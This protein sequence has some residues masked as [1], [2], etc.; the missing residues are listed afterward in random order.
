MELKDGLELPLAPVELQPALHDFALWRTCFDACESFVRLAEGDYALRL[1]VPLGVLRARYAV[2][3]HVIREPKRFADTGYSLNFLARAEG[4]CALRGRFGLR[5]LAGAAGGS[6]LEY[7]VWATALGVC[8]R[9]PPWQFDHAL[10][11]LLNDVLAEF[12]SA[13]LAQHGLAPNR[14]TPAAAR[15]PRV[16]AYR[17]RGPRGLPGRLFRRPWTA[18]AGEIGAR[19]SSVRARGVPGWVWCAT[20]ACTV[21][22]LYGAYWFDGS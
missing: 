22:L 16:F 2:R 15:G 19:L 9:L 6:R 13:V 7:E 8:S 1:T 5:L 21:L 14:A 20:L 10:R 11:T 3:I 12:R 18:G 17:L 4:F